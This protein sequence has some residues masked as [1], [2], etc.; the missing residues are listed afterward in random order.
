MMQTETKRALRA[1]FTKI[2]LV[3]LLL[4]IVA[5]LCCYII[6]SP[7]MQLLIV[8]LAVLAAAGT[9]YYF[10]SIAPLWAA[11]PW[12]KRLLCVPAIVAETATLAVAGAVSAFGYVAVTGK[13]GSG[14]LSG[15][16]VRS[17]D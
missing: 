17:W 5:G 2:A 16:G 8:A 1:L 10:A 7:N 9:G 13:S 4:A 11:T 3:C 6:P 12:L 14:G 15:G